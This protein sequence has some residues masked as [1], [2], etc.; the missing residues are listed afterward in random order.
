MKIQLS[1]HFTYGRMLRFTMPSIIM[2]LFSSIYV[3]VDGLFVANYVGSNALAATNI[4]YP[5]TALASALGFMLGIGGNA[6]V[7]KTLGE[8]KKELA[9]KYFSMIIT[10]I[11]TISLFFS[12][13]GAIF[14][15]P[16]CY[17]LG[18]SD[19]LIGYCTTYGKIIVFGAVPFMLQI[20]FQVFCI[21]AE[22]PNLGLLCTIGAGGTNIILDYFFVAVFHW[23]IAGAASATVI[24][25]CVGGLIPLI[26]FLSPN[27]SLLRLTKPNL[28]PRV[29]GHSAV[30]GSSEMVSNLSYGVVTF[31]YNLQLM[32][33]AGETGVAA[34]AVIMYVNMIFTAIL[35]GFSI[36]I[37]P[38]IGFHYGAQNKEELQNL[39]R[40]CMKMIAVTSIFTVIAAQIAAGPV[41]DIFCKGDATL[42]AMTTKGFH[43]FSIAFLFCGF[44]IFGSCF[45]TSLC[46]GKISAAISFLRTLLMES[47]MILL[48]PLIFGLNGIFM[49]V[50]V[51]EIVTLGVTT[52]FLITQRKK[53]GYI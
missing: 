26:Y 34:I 22:R 15:K 38:V 37:G 43:I 31:L 40:R 14:I 6:E 25:Y 51:T 41:T 35:M 42:E 1:D 18:A 28:Y 45:F 13:L 12:I 29:L 44:N 21:T 9:C 48:L 30:N 33:L 17:L 4:F 53:Y 50:P 3:I 20:T 23:G 2:M 10:A 19:A 47:G 16:I 11:V 5:A 8:G 49:A 7:A 39:F 46:N 27:K 52:I 32:R 36:G 24:G